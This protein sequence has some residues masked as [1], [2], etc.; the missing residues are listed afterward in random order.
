VRYHYTTYPAVCTVF[1][2]GFRQFQQFVPAVP[3]V[4]AVC[5]G[6]I[7]RKALPG[8]K[9]RALR[10]ASF[11]CSKSHERCEWRHSSVQKPRALRV[12]SFIGSFFAKSNFLKEIARKMTFCVTIQAISEDFPA[13]TLLKQAKVPSKSHKT[14]FFRQKM[15]FWPFGLYLIPALC[16]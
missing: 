12:A 10:V 4:S 11:I 1:S 16:L 5:P 7:R 6:G 2:G 13:K 14:A 8:S 9:P 3:A 15:T